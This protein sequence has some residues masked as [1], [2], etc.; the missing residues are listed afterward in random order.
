MRVE[1][2]PS[3]LTDERVGTVEVPDD[4]PGADRPELEIDRQHRRAGH[5]RQVSVGVVRVRIEGPEALERGGLAGRHRRALFDV[6]DAVAGII[7]HFHRRRLGPRIPLPGRPRPPERGEHPVG[8]TITGQYRPRGMHQC[9]VVGHDVGA[10]ARSH[11]RVSTSRERRDVLV[12]VDRL[13]TRRLRRHDD[14]RIAGNDLQPSAQFAQLAVESTQV[15]GELRSPRRAGAIPQTRVDHEQRCDGL[16][17][18]GGGRPGRIVGQAQILAEPHQTRTQCLLLPAANVQPTR[19]AATRSA[20]RL[21]LCVPGTPP[22]IGDAVHVP[23][24]VSPEAPHNT[25]GLTRP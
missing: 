2:P 3:E 1:V 20:A 21:P 7:R 14:R 10:Q 4:G 18:R 5:R 11:G 24:S 16:V 15:G 13:V 17:I 9:A 8:V 12:P 23:E 19:W 22:L 25:V 6:R